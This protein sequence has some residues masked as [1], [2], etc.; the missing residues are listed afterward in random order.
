MA[1][2]IPAILA[3]NYTDLKGKIEKYANLTSIV[4]IDV[5]DGNFVPSISWPMQLSDEK[6]VQ[7]I[8]E[9]KEGLPSWEKIDFEFDLMIK[10]AHK[11]FD[12][13][14]RL[15]AKRIIF[16]IEAEDNIEEFKEFLEGID[17]Y[18]RENIEIG[19]ALNNTTQIETLNHL[20][21]YVDFIQCMG[22]EKIGF[23]GQDFDEKVL[24]QISSL[25]Q[26]YPELIISVDGGVSENTAKDLI[27]KGA[28]RLVIGS[29]LE[30]S[31]DIRE[32][33]KYFESL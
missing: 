31:F 2:I 17:M 4:Q 13:F 26:K 28:N 5:C 29:A 24:E 20:I 22:I 27:Q 33:I 15:G 12:F 1:E 14:V 6:S 18:F 11:Q 30:D 8:L 16:H 3:K 32:S 23:Q 25:R 7:N 19:L 21:S 10:N 9:E